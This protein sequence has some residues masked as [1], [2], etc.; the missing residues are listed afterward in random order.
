MEGTQHSAAAQIQALLDVVNKKHQ[1]P[2]KRFGGRVRAPPR[3]YSLRS[4][5]NVIFG[6]QLI[7]ILC[8]ADSVLPPLQER[9]ELTSL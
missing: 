5:V 1:R 2:Q 8:S 3:V 9:A 4:P 6:G 7:S